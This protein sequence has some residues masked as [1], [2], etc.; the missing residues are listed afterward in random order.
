MN[1]SVRL[2]MFERLVEHNEMPFQSLEVQSHMREGFL[3]MLLPIYPYLWSNIKRVTGERNKAPACMVSPMFFWSHSYP[4]TRQRSAA[5]REGGDNGGFP[6]E[7]EDRPEGDN[8][9]VML[10]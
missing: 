4:E 1:L 8:H 5:N 3:P 6:F 7:M 9:M 10:L 2:S